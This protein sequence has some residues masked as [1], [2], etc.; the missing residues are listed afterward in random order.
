M[1]ELQ[2]DTLVDSHTRLYRKG[3]KQKRGEAKNTREKRDV[4][5]GALTLLM[6]AKFL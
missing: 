5:V 3:E 4:D 1:K 6:V 2:F